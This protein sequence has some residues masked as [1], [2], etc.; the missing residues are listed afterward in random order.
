MLPLCHAY[1]SWQVQKLSQSTG[2]QE[3]KND[4][5]ARGLK[6]HNTIKLSVGNIGVFL[7]T[8]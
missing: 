8:G 4:G 2:R 1:E 6:V 5:G 3:N 7:V